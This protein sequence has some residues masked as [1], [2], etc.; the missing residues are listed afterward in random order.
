MWT[1]IDQESGAIS[2]Q[3]IRPSKIL[4]FLTPSEPKDDVMT[5]DDSGYTSDEDSTEMKTLK[6]EFPPQPTAGL[7]PKKLRAP[8]G[9]P[10][11]AAAS[12]LQ[13]SY[14]V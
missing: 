5:D 13:R 10:A 11:E 4:S 1:A 8:V 3:N 9:N 6:K 12:I 14:T 2:P 7:D